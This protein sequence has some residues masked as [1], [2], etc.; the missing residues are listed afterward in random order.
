MLYAVRSTGMIEY[1]Y[2]YLYGAKTKPIILGR[3]NYYSTLTT[4]FIETVCTNINQWV[5]EGAV[6]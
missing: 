2:Y 4:S 3:S 6:L 1:K 5:Q